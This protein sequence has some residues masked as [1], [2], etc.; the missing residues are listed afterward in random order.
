MQPQGQ[1][2][3]EVLHPNQDKKRSVLG[4]GDLQPGGRVGFGFLQRREL[5]S[6]YR[7]ARRQGVHVVGD[8]FEVWLPGCPDQLAIAELVPNSQQWSQS[9]LE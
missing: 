1:C 4:S 2:S 7:L 8:E 3:G 6:R 5:F 9:H